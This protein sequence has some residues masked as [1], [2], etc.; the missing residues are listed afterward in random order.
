MPY[1]NMLS[2]E[3]TRHDTSCDAF[4]VFITH[5]DFPIHPIFVDGSIAKNIQLP[6]SLPPMYSILN[7]GN[8]VNDAKRRPI[9][10]ER[11]TPILHEIFSPTYPHHLNDDAFWQQPASKLGCATFNVEMGPW[12]FLISGAEDR[13]TRQIAPVS[14]YELVCRLH[15]ELHKPMEIF[16][17]N[18]S[19]IPEETIGLV[20]DYQTMLC[21]TDDHWKQRTGL[22]SDRRDR[23]YQRI[24]F[25]HRNNTGSAR[26]IMAF[27]CNYQM[28]RSCFITLS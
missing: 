23:K 10:D 15:R 21:K 19:I 16:E 26:R 9:V 12:A 14:I 18:L 7:F 2:T 13:T 3:A 4:D 27:V 20:S 24:D 25:L 17:L 22:V 1:M 5:D 28:Q 11:Y 8:F 6:M